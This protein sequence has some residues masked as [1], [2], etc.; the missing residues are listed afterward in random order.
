MSNFGE[1]L[2]RERELRQITLREVAEATK[3]NI[4]YLEA[5]ERNEFSHLPGGL[6]NRGFVRAYCQFIG[7]DA[8]AMVNAYVLE[9]RTQGGFEPESPTPLLRG[10][11]AP[12]R[13]RAGSSASARSG[14][15][16]E[17]RRV[18]IWVL[19]LAVAIVGC[20]LLIWRSGL[21]RGET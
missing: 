7:I 10:T 19:C 12:T 17:R 1:E 11:A 5:L 21:L 4:R 2:R 13:S 8:D 3:V 15:R 9:E 20:A 18:W 6:F 16:P 14:S